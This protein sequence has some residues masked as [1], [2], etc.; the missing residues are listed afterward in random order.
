MRDEN[1]KMMGYFR[2]F[3]RQVERVE[4]IQLRS[5]NLG[6]NAPCLTK[7][8]SNSTVCFV[9]KE[10]DEIGISYLIPYMYIY[11]YIYYI[12]IFIELDDD[13]SLFYGI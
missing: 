3:Q 2:K 7:R 6:K 1:R 10:L 13:H 12:N 4:T 9:S 11:V 8:P 5:V